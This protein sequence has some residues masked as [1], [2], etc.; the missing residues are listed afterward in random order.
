MNDSKD[1]FPSQFTK[2]NSLASD[3]ATSYWRWG[4]KEGV[5]QF[6]NQ[7]NRFLNAYVGREQKVTITDKDSG[8]RVFGCPADRGIPEWVRRWSNPGING[9]MS[10]W[11]AA[12]LS[13][14]YNTVALCNN[15]T[16]GLWQKKRSQVKRADA[17][18]LAGDL[19]MI[20]YFDPAIVGT[21]P[22]F[23]AYWHNK[24]ENGWANVVFVDGHVGFISMVQSAAYQ[25][26]LNFQ[27]GTNWTVLFD[28]PKRQ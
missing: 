21:S 10:L 12:G 26:G 28:G 5:A 7:Q 15:G 2:P 16:L 25:N 18:I 23:K 11:D 22:Y 6:T 8:L 19:T 13:Y 3:A 24:N 20:A 1:V 27:N 17:C 9:S 14:H 4:G